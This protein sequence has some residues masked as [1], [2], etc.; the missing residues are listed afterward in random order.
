MKDYPMRR[1]NQITRCTHRW[2]K[3]QVLNAWPRGDRYREEKQAR[4]VNA[5][6]FETPHLLEKFENAVAVAFF[7][8]AAAVPA[9]PGAGLAVCA[10]AGSGA[11]IAISCPC[12]TLHLS[13]D[14]FW[15]EPHRVLTFQVAVLPALG[16]RW[17][18]VPWPCSHRRTP[19]WSSHS[20][21]PPSSLARL[22]VSAGRTQP[23]C[24][25]HPAPPQT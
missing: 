11:G 9:V 17:D 1:N 8:A 20:R 7:A 25:H 5:R 13:L 23:A 22:S 19:P 16:R 12:A 14:L 2:W 21:W 3:L 24:S 4:Y 18:T 6:Y 10:R 15:S